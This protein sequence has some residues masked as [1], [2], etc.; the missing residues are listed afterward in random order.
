MTF[1]QIKNSLFN[2]LIRFD[3]S[4]SKAIKRE[5]E[6]EKSLQENFAT[7]IR[8]FEAWVKTKKEVVYKYSEISGNHETAVEKL[9]HLQV[10][11]Q[12]ALMTSYDAIE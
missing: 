8:D 2:F 6:C 3:Q 10:N 4:R 9:K 5:K 12:I 7:A 1:F 11:T